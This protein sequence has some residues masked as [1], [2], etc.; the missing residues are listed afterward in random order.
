MMDESRVEWDETDPFYRKGSYNG[1]EIWIRQDDGY[2]NATKIY[3][4]ANRTVTSPTWQKIAKYWRNHHSPNVATDQLS[5]YTI[6]GGVHPGTFVHPDLIH[7]IASDH[8]IEYAFA[9]K[10]IMDA[11]NET[12]PLNE[13]ANPQAV[14]ELLEKKL[15]EQQEEIDENQAVIENQRIKIIENRA[16]IQGQRQTIRQQARTIQQ[17]GVPPLNCSKLL[18]LVSEEGGFF[19]TAVSVDSHFPNWIKKW[20]FASSM[21]VKQLIHENWGAYDFPLSQLDEVIQFIREM[22]PRPQSEEPLN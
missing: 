6:I 19:V 16:E 18:K 7:F 14:I 4:R 2:I 3:D 13:D 15:S 8:S 12:M 20:I 5:N 11:V 21:A 1:I 17:T 22:D 9:V 10:A